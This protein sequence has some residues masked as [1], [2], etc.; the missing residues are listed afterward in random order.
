MKE[1]YDIQDIINAE[2]NLEPIKCRY[3]S[4]IGEVTYYQY[5]NNAHCAKCGR[6]QLDE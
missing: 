5:L 6:W 4:H 1:Y 3:C 2:C